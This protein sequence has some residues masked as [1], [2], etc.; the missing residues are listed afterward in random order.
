MEIWYS[1]NVEFPYATFDIFHTRI[2]D[3][4]PKKSQ[5]KLFCFWLASFLF[6]IAQAADI[7]GPI[8]TNQDKPKLNIQFIGNGSVDLGVE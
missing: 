2:S 1:V 6:I 5:F 8:E 7:F 3:S 4:R